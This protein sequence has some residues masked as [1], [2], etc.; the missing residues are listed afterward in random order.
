MSDRKTSTFAVKLLK[1]HTHAGKTYAAGEVLPADKINQIVADWL[2]E[3]EVGEKA[4]TGAA[5][6]PAVVPA[7]TSKTDK[8]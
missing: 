6:K 4:D 7:A 5:S 3:N 1:A 2:V 8:E